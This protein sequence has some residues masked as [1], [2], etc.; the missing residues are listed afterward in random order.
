MMGLRA[1]ALGKDQ[2]LGSVAR[3]RARSPGSPA[4]TG[5]SR[6][7]AS[8][9]RAMSSAC[10]RRARASDGLALEILVQERSGR[11][12]IPCWRVAAGERLVNGEPG[13]IGR[14]R[15]GATALRHQHVADVVLAHRQVALPLRVGRVAA[16]ECSLP[17]SPRSASSR[18]APSSS[19]CAGR[20]DTDICTTSMPPKSMPCIICKTPITPENDSSEHV[21]SSAVGGRLKVKDFLCKSCN[22]GA[23]QSWD[24]ALAQ[25]MHPLCH[26]FAI[27]RDR[28]DLPPLPIVTT[29]GEELTLLPGGGFA[30]TDPKFE[31]SPVA[32]GTGI[33][34]KARSIGEARRILQGLKKKHPN[35]D[36]EAE[37][38]KAEE[39]ISYPEG[40]VHHELQFGGT[41]GGRSMVKT[42]AAFAR[43]LGIPTTACGI[44]AGYLRDELA[45]APF[46]FYY[47]SDLVKDRPVGVPFHC[48]AVH[49]DPANGLLLGYVE[50]FGAV[51]I[52]TCL[53][54]TYDHPAVSGCYAIDPTNGR[55]FTLAV[56]LPFDRAEIAAIYAYERMTS[57]A[58]GAALDAVIGPAVKRNHAVGLQHAVEDA[59]RYG[60]AHS[61]AKKGEMLTP[62]QAARVPGLVVKRFMP[63]IIQHSTRRGR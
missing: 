54:E 9:L 35:L 46:G 32:E 20:R 21:V 3:L 58:M 15:T 28:G 49:G 31:R 55:T 47:A 33:Q 10:V 22:S 19:D 53:S 26:L 43:H 45:E 1:P 23:G 30:L 6:P 25:Q 8:S 2:S 42:A 7:S 36:V 61:G 63:Y 13:L 5:A 57:Q 50:Y 48:V 39:T 18:N 12:A 56:S 27:V 59:A 51:R 34:V 11:A 4:P 37:M 14:Q 52:V 38:A 17:R 29:A 24:A 16:G 41:E 40:A 60:L 44:A 62:E